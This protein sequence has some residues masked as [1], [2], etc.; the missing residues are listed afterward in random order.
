MIRQLAPCVARELM[1][2][3]DRIDAAEALRIGLVNRVVPL[4]Q[5]MP[6]AMD[7]ARRIAEKSPLVLRLLKRTLSAGAD[8]PL[9][10]ALAHEQAMIGLV[11]DSRDAHEGCTAFLEKRPARFT[12]E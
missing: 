6:Q 7:L 10:S 2:T 4:D 8:M 3:G 1:F 12:G 11:L 9:P 5:L